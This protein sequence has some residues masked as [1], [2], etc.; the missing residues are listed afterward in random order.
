MPMK[1]RRRSVGIALILLV[2]IPGGL[3]YRVWSRSQADQD[4][5]VAVRAGDTDRAVAALN[6]G[7]N[8]NLRGN[9]MDVPQGPPWEALLQQL[10]FLKQTG[11]PI[12]RKAR[13][14][15][16]MAPVLLLAMGNGQT[17]PRL[18]HALLAKGAD[19]NRTRLNG[20][21]PLM[22]M[23]IQG[24]V[25]ILDDLL[26]HGA[27][28]GLKATNGDTALSCAISYKR[29]LVVRDL[30]RSK[31]AVDAVGGLNAALEYALDHNTNNLRQN[32]GNEIVKAILEAGANANA[33]A[34]DGQPMTNIAASG[35]AGPA[36]Y[37]LIGWAVGPSNGP[38]VVN[39]Q[40]LQ[41][42]YAM[43]APTLQALL[44]HDAQVDAADKTGM[45]PLMWSAK[46]GDAASV[47]LLLGHHA[48]VDAKNVAGATPLIYAAASC[49]PECVRLLLERHASVAAAD[50][51]GMTPLIAAAKS[52]YNQDGVR[53][54]LG[55]GAEVDARDQ[56]GG[57]ALIY[58]AQNSRFYTALSGKN[59]PSI[60]PTLQLLLTHHA[61]IDLQNSAGDDALLCAARS[62]NAED[63]RLLFMYGADVHHRN[64]AGETAL[65]AVLSALPRFGPGFGN[66]P[67][68]VAMANQMCAPYIEVV[69]MLLAHGVE[70][71]AKDRQGNTALSQVQ[72]YPAQALID[73]L[74][75]AGAH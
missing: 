3:L 46:E 2:L 22:Q 58:A 37:Q 14:P 44:D 11:P 5:L 64:R 24:Q 12:G 75:K 26:A 61:R 15:H 55:H 74:K 72:Q 35:G 60:S 18:I 30:L 32:T 73:L 38:T 43:R 20:F 7:A 6:A 65:F 13:N 42:N 28:A 39:G 29:P 59:L 16:N 21:T 71:N 31:A 41:P 10:G 56:S 47:R 68:N 27:N 69:R 62:G 54:L 70:I 52:G 19:P 33:R 49:N 51:T 57:A 63:V 9:R 40:I 23:A 67:S 1:S 8:P 48:S 4:L 25:E 50:R 53:L 45:T 66:R 36:P 17:D 34:S